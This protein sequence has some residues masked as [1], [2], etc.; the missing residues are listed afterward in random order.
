MSNLGVMHIKQPYGY[1]DLIIPILAWSECCDVIRL[2]G[3]NHTFNLTYLQNGDVLDPYV[4]RLHSML[5]TI[6]PSGTVGS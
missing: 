4:G 5:L 6:L 3:V 2:F 1:G